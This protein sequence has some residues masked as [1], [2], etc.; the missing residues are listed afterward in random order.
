MEEDDADYI[1][2]S[3]FVLAPLP[4]ILSELPLFED[5]SC[6]TTFVQKTIKMPHSSKPKKH[7]RIKGP[8]FS[9]KKKIQKPKEEDEKEVQVFK[10]EY[11]MGISFSDAVLDWYG[12]NVGLHTPICDLAMRSYGSSVYVTEDIHQNVIL[13]T[14]FCRG[15]DADALN[16]LN[17]FY[18]DLPIHLCFS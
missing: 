11:K 7:S 16:Q 5:Q 9:A 13:L 6:T 17:T 1:F 18:D 3:Q 14:E 2:A 10:T 15:N 4:E 8:R 12:M